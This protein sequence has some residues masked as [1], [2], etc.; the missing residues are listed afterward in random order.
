MNQLFTCFIATPSRTPFVDKKSKDDSVTSTY[1]RIKQHAGSLF[2]LSDP[3]K[4]ELFSEET[5]GVVDRLLTSAP[6]ERGS[7]QELLESAWLALA[8]AGAEA[9]G[10]AVEEDDE[11]CS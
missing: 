4:D 3:A 6:E 7:A 9:G 10:Q 2:P 1:E 11:P 5:K 8:G